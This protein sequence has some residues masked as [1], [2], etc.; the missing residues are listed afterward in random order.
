MKHFRRLATFHCSRRDTSKVTPEAQSAM[1]CR[2]YQF[3]QPDC[4]S[5]GRPPYQYVDQE[6]AAK[7]LS[8]RAQPINGFDGIDTVSRGHC[9]QLS[10]LSH[11][12]IR[13]AVTGR[14]VGLEAELLRIALAKLHGTIPCSDMINNC[15][16][17]QLV[18]IK[19]PANLGT[20]RGKTDQTTRAIS[21]LG[22][23]VL[24]VQMTRSTRSRPK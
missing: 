21:L 6:A 3:V 15:V 9:L 23:S 5:R 16:H 1:Y 14:N 2:E 22:G 19:D 13:L 18:L 8:Y 10:K 20:T 11:P 7:S 17:S 12:N 24:N 4:H